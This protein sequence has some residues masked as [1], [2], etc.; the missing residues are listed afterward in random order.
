MSRPIRLEVDYRGSCACATVCSCRLTHPNVIKIREVFLTPTHLAL[1]MELASHG[2]L[3]RKLNNAKCLSVS[4]LSCMCSAKG[5]GGTSTRNG[6]PNREIWLRV[7][8]PQLVVVHP[9]HS[10]KIQSADTIYCSK[11]GQPV[12]KTACKVICGFEVSLHLQ[13]SEK[14]ELCVAAGHLLPAYRRTDR[15]YNLRASDRHNE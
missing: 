7:T 3:S 4:A 8:A 1:A 15:H 9:E 12:I 6:C 10:C 11:S 5:W 2:N 13:L 14:G